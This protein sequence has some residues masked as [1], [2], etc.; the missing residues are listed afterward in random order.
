MD[1]SAWDS[2]KWGLIKRHLKYSAAELELFKSDPRNEAVLD[3]GRALQEKR[4]IIE[5][6]ESHGCNSRHRVGDKFIFDGAGNLLTRQNPERICVFV[7]NA[8]TG[9][10][11]AASELF[12]A[13]VDPNEMK[14]RRSG[15]FDVGIQCGG[16]GKV[17]IELSMAEKAGEPTRAD[18]TPEE[19]DRA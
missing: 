10:I 7:L 12:Y 2:V 17:V 9:L 16:W 6:V 15:C 18:G 11:F 8:A 13:G 19:E 14:F 1:K 4:I 5:V 3:M